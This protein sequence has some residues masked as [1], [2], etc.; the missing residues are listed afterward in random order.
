VT[1][2]VGVILALSFKG[3]WRTQNQNG[4]RSD[5]PI[6]QPTKNCRLGRFNPN[7]LK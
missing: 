1:R 3:T 6:A 2:S 4:E 5:Q 7:L